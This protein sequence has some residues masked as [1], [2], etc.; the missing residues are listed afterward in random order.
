MALFCKTYVGIKTK[1]K[2]NDRFLSNQNYWGWG[3][4]LK[5]VLLARS[6]ALNS[7]TAANYKLMFGV[8]RGLILPQ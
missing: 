4:G 5:P 1:F 6:R 8:Q 2:V 7:N 3:V